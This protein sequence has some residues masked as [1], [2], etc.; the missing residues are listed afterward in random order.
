VVHH[1]ILRGLRF[2]GGND[3]GLQNGAELQ[4]VLPDSAA[5]RAGLR[6]GDRIVAVSGERVHNAARLLGLLGTW[7]AES[8]VALHLQRGD[9]AI[10]LDVTLEANVAGALGLKV[11]VDGRE[12]TVTGLVQGGPASAGGLQ[13]GDVLLGLDGRRLRGFRDLFQRWHR[14]QRLAGDQVELRLR[15]DGREIELPIELGPR[16]RLDFDPLGGRSPGLF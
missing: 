7:P 13:Q 6:A 15:R 1:G 2:A 12:L 5:E 9:A 4:A 8:E 16:W 3:D 10:L 14:A 11:E